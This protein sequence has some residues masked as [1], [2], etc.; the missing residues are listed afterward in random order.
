MWCLCNVEHEYI[1]VFRKGFSG[2]FKSTFGRDLRRRS[3]YFWEE[4]NLWFSALWEFP[5][6]RQDIGDLGS[7][8]RS[9]SYPIEFPYR[10]LQMYS[11]YGD[12]VFDPFLGLGTTLTA[13]LLSIMVCYGFALDSGLF[14]YLRTLYG[15]GDVLDY[16]DRFVRGRYLRHLDFVRGSEL[17]GK[18]FK[19]WDSF[20][21]C[22]VKTRQEEFLRLYLLRSLGL[23][24]IS[25]G[26]LS[27]SAGY[28]PFC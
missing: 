18:S 8:S 22:M 3:S 28:V 6:V 25:D 14:E 4:R 20:L 10:L 12:V 2:R 21:G 23:S 11:C 16:A 24:G 17:S 26:V 7:R 5:G 27:L 13:S 19:Y 9:G 1:L 15:S